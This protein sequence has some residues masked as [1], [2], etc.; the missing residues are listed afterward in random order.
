MAYSNKGYASS[1]MTS[2]LTVTWDGSHAFKI[3]IVN[4]SSDDQVVSLDFS[5]SREPDDGF[6]IKVRPTSILTIEPGGFNGF[7]ITK[8]S[9]VAGVVDVYWW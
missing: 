6:P 4:N 2:P 3:S 7:T 9:G 1:D 8:D 5:P